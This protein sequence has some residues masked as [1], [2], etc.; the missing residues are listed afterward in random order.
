MAGQDAHT[1]SEP[2]HSTYQ[3]WSAIVYVLWL[4]YTHILVYARDCMYTHTSFL[5]FFISSLFSLSQCQKFG[6]YHKDDPSSFK[7][8]DNFSLYPQV[9]QNTALYH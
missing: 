9:N 5:H 7:F 4:L 1:T 8:N 3:Y 2:Q 6:E